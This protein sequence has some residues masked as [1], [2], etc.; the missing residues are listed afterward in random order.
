MYNSVIFSS[1][2]LSEPSI[3]VVTDDFLTGAPFALPT[4]YS[5]DPDYAAGSLQRLRNSTT[6]SR[7]DTKG[8]IKAYGSTALTSEWGN[9]L[10][11]MT[12]GKTNHSLLTMIDSDPDPYEYLLCFR[13][14]CLS[15]ELYDVSNFQS[16]GIY[17][18]ERTNI[19]LPG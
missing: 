13:R 5:G 1:T 6:T 4:W 8:C 7:L 10:A 17:T 3:F 18:L 19:L 12:A 15:G 11:V 9:A 2:S 14:V 16:V